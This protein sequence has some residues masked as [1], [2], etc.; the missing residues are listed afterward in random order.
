MSGRNVSLIGFLSGLLGSLA[1]CSSIPKGLEPVKGFELERYLGTWY[2]IARLDHS[3]EQDLSHVTASYS[4]RPDGK[5]E[6]LN[7]GFNAKKDKWVQAR[8]MAVFSGDENVGSLKVT[9][10]WP[11]AGGYNILALDR[12]NYQ[13]AMVC[14]NSRK[15]LWILAYRPQMEKDQLDELLRQAEKWGFQTE[16]LI[17]PVQEQRELYR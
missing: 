8:A 11:F 3:F 4:L 12:E 16:N 2:E 9:F 10:F 7:R 14:G 5:I 6:V 17:Y 15:Y 1:G 13:Y